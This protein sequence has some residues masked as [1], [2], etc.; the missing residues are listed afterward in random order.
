M[1][2]CDKGLNRITLAAVWKQIEMRQ[3]KAGRWVRGVGSRIRSSQRCPHLNSGSCG[4]VILQAREIKVAMELRLLVSWPWDGDIILDF[5]GWM[6]VVRKVLV[7]ARVRQEIEEMMQC[8]KD[9]PMSQAMQ[10]V[11]RSSKRQGPRFS[12]RARKESSLTDILNLDHWDP[13][14][15]SDLQNCKIIHLCCLKPLSLW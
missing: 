13:F 1:E 4:Y 12:S 8:E 2:W 5:P 15:T 9:L 7:S 6:N 14:W 10:V 3:V 11:Y